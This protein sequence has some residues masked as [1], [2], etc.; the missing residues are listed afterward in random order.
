LER[1]RSLRRQRIRCEDN[2]K[3]EYKL[4]VRGCGLT[5]CDPEQG[6]VM[7]CYENNNETSGSI[8]GEEF[9]E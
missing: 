2:I 7:G 9:L 5:S 1:K 6:P 4:S 8:K 3:I